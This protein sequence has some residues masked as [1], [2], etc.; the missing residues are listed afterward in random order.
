MHDN[1]LDGLPLDLAAF[2]DF[3][4]KR[5]ERMQQR[6]L[7]ILGVSEDV[8]SPA[9]DPVPSSTAAANLGR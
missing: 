1:D 4:D 7:K 8:S 5:K 2:L 9:S 3:Y 6:L